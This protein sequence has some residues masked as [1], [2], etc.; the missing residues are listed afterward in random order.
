MAPLHLLGFV[1]PRCGELAC[2]K[3]QRL[4]DLWARGPWILRLH[5]LLWQG[6]YLGHW[7]MVRTLME[8]QLRGLP[9]S[10]PPHELRVV[11]LSSC[12]HTGARWEPN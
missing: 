5:A 3:Q 1:W 4:S 12:T 2:L 10:R 9:H 7:L 6:N 8:A 11:F